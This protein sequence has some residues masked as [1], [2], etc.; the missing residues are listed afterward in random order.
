MIRSSG[1]LFRAA[2]R[3]LKMTAEFV[4]HCREQLVLE[5]GFPTRAKTLVERGC[6]NRRRHSLINR[7]LDCP[8]SFARVGDASRESGESRVFDQCGR[9]K[10]EQPGR[11]YAA[12]P[13]QFGDI[14]EIEVILI[15][16]GIA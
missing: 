13:P 4:A 7:R 11:D 12:A 14:T 8:P 16:V 3:L 15:V 9:R 1:L 2:N 5:I 10:I 6:E